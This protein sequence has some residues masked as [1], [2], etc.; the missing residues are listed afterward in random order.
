MPLPSRRPRWRPGRY[1]TRRPCGKVEI[2]GDTNSTS[3][4]SHEHSGGD[5]DCD[6][7]E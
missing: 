3:G 5:L 7:G 6:R 2:G 1:R 4:S